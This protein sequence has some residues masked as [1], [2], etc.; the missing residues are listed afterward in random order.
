MCIVPAGGSYQQL[1]P[2]CTC[3]CFSCSCCGHEWTLQHV[4]K[5][6]VSMKTRDSWEQAAAVK[7]VLATEQYIALPLQRCR[8]LL[9]HRYP[10]AAITGRL[11]RFAYACMSNH[12]SVRGALSVPINAAKGSESIEDPKPRPLRFFP[13]LVCNQ[14]QSCTADSNVLWCACCGT[15]HVSELTALIT[16][17]G[18]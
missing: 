16:T 10:C 8:K 3:C 15:H 17:Y 13:I 5:D 6:K 11:C 7:R 12:T 18:M 2:T 4:L 14:I 9:K 1:L